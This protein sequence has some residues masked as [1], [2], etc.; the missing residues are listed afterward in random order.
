MT[1]VFRAQMTAREGRWRLYVVLLNTLTPWPEY[2]FGPQ[3]PTFTDRVNALTA[4]GY[5]PV[6]GAAWEWFE[7]REDPDDPASPVVLI[8][9]TDVCSWPGVTS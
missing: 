6:P 8:A 5:E 4:L 2:V 3:V 9:S 7:D 1:A